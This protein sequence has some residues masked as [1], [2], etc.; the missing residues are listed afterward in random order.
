MVSSGGTL[1]SLNQYLITCGCIPVKRS[2]CSHVTRPIHLFSLHTYACFTAH[3]LIQFPPTK[4]NDLHPYVLPAPN[5]GLK[6][7]FLSVPLCRSPHLSKSDHSRTTNWTHHHS[8]DR[9]R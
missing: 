6:I 4:Q 3:L 9:G 8:G 7:A 1:F 2:T 5:F